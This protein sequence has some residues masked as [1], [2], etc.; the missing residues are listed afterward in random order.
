MENFTETQEIWREISSLQGYTDMG[1]KNPLNILNS[2]SSGFNIDIILFMDGCI[3]YS[4]LAAIIVTA[5]TT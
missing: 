5:T 3:G 1:L 4:I 2:F